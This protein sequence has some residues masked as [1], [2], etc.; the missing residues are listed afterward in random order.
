LIDQAP[1]NP[2]PVAAA[3]EGVPIA[4]EQRTGSYDLESVAGEAEQ[5]VRPWAAYQS[6]ATVGTRRGSGG[7]AVISN[8]A[9]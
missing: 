1:T 4:W 5:A 9:I 7:C 2:G 8:S 3:F 6:P